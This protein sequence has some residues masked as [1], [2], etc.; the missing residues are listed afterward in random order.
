M[1]WEKRRDSKSKYLYRSIRINGKVTKRYIGPE[2]DPVTRLVDKKLRLDCAEEAALTLELQNERSDFKRYL[3][4]LNALSS[5]VRFVLQ[6]CMWAEGLE[7]KKGLRALMSQNHRLTLEDI[8]ANNPELP[9]LEEFH[10]LV[11]LSRKG[12]DDAAEE[13]QRIVRHHKDIW[14]PYADL[15]RH[16]EATLIEMISG[17]EVVLKESLRSKVDDLKD[18]IRGKADNPVDALLVDQIMISWLE[19]RYTHMATL[20]SQ[21]GERDSRFWD[22]QYARAHSRYLAA[23]RELVDIR[24]IYGDSDGVS[25]LREVV[26]GN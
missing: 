18:S 15:N 10:R 21:N 20:Q 11:R 1:G 2:H 6:L 24:E 25:H 26:D 14:D 13:L 5:H 9:T 4:A 7:L 16:V 19:L 17:G 23:I 3:T 8:S 22:A 12:D